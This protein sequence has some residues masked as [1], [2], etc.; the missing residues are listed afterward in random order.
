MILKWGGKTNSSCPCEHYGK[1]VATF[2]MEVVAGKI[3]MSATIPIENILQDRIS[4][5]I[6]NLFHLLESIP[7]ECNIFLLS[8]AL[9]VIF[10]TITLRSSYYSLFYSFLILALEVPH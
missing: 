8:H 6:L 4:Y 5:P 7:D 10:L 3:T 2:P 9:S 1:Q